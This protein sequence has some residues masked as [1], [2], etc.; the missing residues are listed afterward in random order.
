MSYAVKSTVNGRGEL[1][2]RLRWNGQTKRSVYGLTPDLSNA[3]V[4]R[5]RRQANH[6]RMCAE[7]V[8][9]HWF[10]TVEI[11]NT[12]AITV[13]NSGVQESHATG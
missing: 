11:A 10:E 5:N 2:L 12:E 9:C 7:Q 8:M 4:N 1:Y 6:V 13:R 3:Y